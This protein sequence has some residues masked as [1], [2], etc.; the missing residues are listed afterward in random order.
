MEVVIYNSLFGILITLVAFQIGIYIS[1][2]IKLPIFNPILIALALIISGLLIFDI[3]YEVYNNGGK[4][5][6]SFLGPA[7]VV[8]AVPLYKQLNL[9]KK[10]LVPILV[11]VIVGST[12][13]IVSVIILGKLLGVD[14]QLIISLIPKSVTTPIGVELSNS[15]GG[16]QSITIVAIVIT[17]I[18]GAVVATTINKY[19]KVKSK[20]AIGVG[21]GTSSHALGT[22]KAFEIGE[23]QGAMSSLSIG[24]AGLITVLIAP[25]IFIVAVK[26]FG[27]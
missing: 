27:L 24:I 15:L 21:I 7:T 19:L 8:L 16:I 17:G 5:I 18:T 3:D 11:G 4:I 20:I 9:L 13:S 23:A 10:N 26:I 6:N 12:T 14:K 2:K 22:T 1:K 25:P